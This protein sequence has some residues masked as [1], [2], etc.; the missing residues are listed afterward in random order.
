[1][2]GFSFPQRTEVTPGNQLVFDRL[3]AILGTVPNLYAAFAWSENA[4]STYLALENS[5]SSLNA[6]QR[7]AI[8]LIVS[9]VNG[10]QYCLTAHS[11]IA[12]MNG[13]DEQQIE[14]I[15][16]G[17]AAFDKQLDAIVRLAKSIAE[18]EGACDEKILDA[19]SGAGLTKENLVD[20]VLVIGSTIIAN[21]LQALIRTPID[22]PLTTNWEEPLR[23]R[24]G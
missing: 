2:K 6:R 23:H 20:L 9:Q 5:K 15:R 24:E 19:F 7:E 22:F 18:N 21:Y 1:M 10:C 13:F 14:E 8:Y 12:R 11:E 4:L 16:L 3:A 17:T